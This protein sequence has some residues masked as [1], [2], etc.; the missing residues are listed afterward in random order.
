M[1][2]GEVR[3]V[4]VPSSIAYG[5]NGFYGKSIPGKKRFVIS[6]NTTLVYEIEV[7]EMK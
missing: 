7:I 6:P 1:K 2:Y 4:V 3:T 5:L